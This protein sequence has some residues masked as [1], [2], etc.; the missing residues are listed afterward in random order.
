MSATA[1]INLRIPER[2]RS[3]IDQAAQ[4]L[5]KTRTAFILEQSIAKAEEIMLN[6]THFRL[7]ES[8][9]DAMK[10]ALDAPLSHDQQIKLQKL[11]AV[12]APWN[13]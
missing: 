5:G 2:E 6:R 8:E 3:L 9:W 12:K 11:F 7:S 13:A 4:V 1:T 10:E